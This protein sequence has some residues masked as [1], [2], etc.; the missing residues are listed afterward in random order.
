[1]ANYLTTKLAARFFS[2]GKTGEYVNL[3]IRGDDM[4][5]MIVITSCQA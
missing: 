4:K 5:L 1:M 2:P 3:S